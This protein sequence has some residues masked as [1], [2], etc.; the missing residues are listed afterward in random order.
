MAV[1]NS[2]ARMTP[3]AVPCL[4]AAALTH[5][6][7][8]P[9]LSTRSKPYAD[10]LARL[11]RFAKY[12]SVHVLL[13]GES[14]TGKSVFAQHLHD[15]SPRRGRVFHRVPLTTI[16]DTLAASDLFGHLPGSFTD[17]RVK[18]AGHFVSAQGGT[19]FLDE[20]GK[21]SPLVQ[22]TLLDAVERHE[23]TP[24]G[25]DRSVRVDVRIV[26]AS[27]VSLQALADEGKFLPDL[28]A[29]LNGFTIEI[30]PLR[31]RRDD[32]PLLVAHLLEVYARDFAYRQ[33]PTIDSDLMKMLVDADW[34][35][36]VR[37]LDATVRGL[38]IEG[39]GAPIITVGHCPESVARLVPSKHNQVDRARILSELQK[40]KKPNIAAVAR[41]CG[42][43][44]T[45][46][47]E[48]MKRAAVI[49]AAIASDL[50]L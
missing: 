25:A 16:G 32:I 4:S 42:V 5:A 29:R 31:E 11:E 27:N 41:K 17:A 36:N 21:A 9:L 40:Q 33:A 45:T 28:L 7:L 35:G 47:Y 34:P 18:R 48:C 46:V 24:V 2:P 43:S 1:A 49:A 20:I 3:S 15:S 50:A 19:L 37:E 14:G 22:N 10:A 26:V 38:L 13:L 23:V 30:P 6:A 12:D 39:E 8:V 44:R